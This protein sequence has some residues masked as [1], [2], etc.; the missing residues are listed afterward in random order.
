MRAA[1]RQ[2][3]NR[4]RPWADDSD[5]DS[6]G[7]DHIWRM[8]GGRQAGRALQDVTGTSGSDGALS[9]RFRVNAGVSRSELN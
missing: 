7:G 6:D 1:V 2:R 5:S 9:R 3:R 4:T 8:K